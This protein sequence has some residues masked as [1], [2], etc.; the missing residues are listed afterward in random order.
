[1]FDQRILTRR[2]TRSTYDRGDGLAENSTLPLSLSPKGW[3]LE[4]QHQINNPAEAFPHVASSW[5][6]CQLLDDCT[7][8]TPTTPTAPVPI[9]HTSTH[10][11]NN[12]P[13]SGPDGIREARQEY[14]DYLFKVGFERSM[15]MFREGQ[16][17]QRMKVASFLFATCRTRL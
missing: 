13:N 17:I 1:M 14:H 16:S 8:S 15:E 9:A 12:Q 3:E 6:L 7:S 4:Y 5:S 11:A 10:A 2:A